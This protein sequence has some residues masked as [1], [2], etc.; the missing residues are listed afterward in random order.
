MKSGKLDSRMLEE[1]VF[2]NFKNRRPEVKERPG[3]GVDCAIID[4]D[5][6]D[7]VMS[8]DPITA[9]ADQLGKIAIH[10]SC[11]DIASQGIAPIG[12][13]LACMF[14]EGTNRETIDYVMKQ[15]G[16]VAAELDV[17]VIGGHTEITAAVNKPIIVSTAVGRRLAKESSQTMSPGDI[18]LMSKTAGI[19]GTAILAH[20]FKDELM[21]VLEA[22]E[23]EAAVQMQES[24]SV[25]KEGIL[26]GEIGVSA[27]HDITEGGVLGAVWELCE[28]SKYGV[29]INENDIPKNAITEKI[30]KHFGI[31]SLRLISSGCM[32]IVAKPE[33]A[34]LIIEEA[35][36]HG[37]LI[38]RI[39]IM[40]DSGCKIEK[41][42]VTEEIEPPGSDELYKVV[43]AD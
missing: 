9:A 40:T 30:C 34:K 33:R 23:M 12:I 38:S 2:N 5:K 3:I 24:M 39:G 31:D 35:G 4:F 8:T 10:V 41:D 19:E 15:A 29:L 1:I 16:E 42:G 43:F 13:M 21:K 25:V 26:A 17:E 7:C 22:D 27:M 32:L 11:N 20:D 37:I 28:L 6:Y 36:K 18:I 14:P